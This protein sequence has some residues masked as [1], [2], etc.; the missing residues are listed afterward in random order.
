MIVYRVI[1]T[2]VTPQF[3]DPK[4][5]IDALV[6]A[7]YGAIA[8]GI[9]IACIWAIVFHKLFE[10]PWNQYIIKKVLNAFEAMQNQNDKNA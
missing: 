6:F 3:V 10:C 1:G 8:F 5:K 4:E 9:V 7:D 2:L